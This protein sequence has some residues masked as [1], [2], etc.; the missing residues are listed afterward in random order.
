MRNLV[1]FFVRTALALGAV[2]TIGVACSSTESTDQQSAQDGGAGAS[3]SSSAGAGGTS[4][5]GAAGSSSEAGGSSGSSTGSGGASATGGSAGSGGGRAGS[6]GAAGAGGSGGAP[7]TPPADA[8]RECG[9][10]TCAPDE[11]CQYPCCGTLPLCMAMP[12]LDGGACPL[13]YQTCFT[14]QTV[15]GCQYSCT[16]PSCT[17]Q[18]LSV[19]GCTIMGR[20]VHC[21]CA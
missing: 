19:P 1:P 6:G 13:G 7:S 15:R 10:V 17:K 21:M 16:V 11:W 8:P 5:A 18:R 14:P 3:G 4:A 20:Q 2:G 12:G 9:P